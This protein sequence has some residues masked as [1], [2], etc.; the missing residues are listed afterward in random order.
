M[1]Y[2]MS[3]I[4]D[5]GIPNADM[6]LIWTTGAWMLGLAL[7]S[8]ACAVLTTR[9]NADVSSNFTADLRRAIFRKTTTLSFEEFSKVGTSSLLT[10]S[11]HDV[12]MLGD[13]ASMVV[14]AVMTVPV[15]FFGGCVFAFLSD[16]VLA[17]VFLLSAPL[18]LLLTWLVA[19]KVGV[20]WENSDKYI[21]EQNR[22]MRE[23]LSGLRVIRAFDKEA[24]EHGRIETATNRMAEN[25]IKANVRANLLTPVC[26]LLLNL[27]T[28][29]MLCI[30]AIRIQNPTLVA[31]GL[32][33]GRII[34]TV[35]YVALILNGLL[36]LS[37]TFI[38]MPHLKVCINRVAEVL[39]LKGIAEQPA[40]ETVTEGS[41]TFDHVSF[42]YPDSELETLT[43]IDMQI[44]AG[45]SVAVI[46]GTGSG[47]STLLKL[48]LCFYAPTQG[49]ISL[50]GKPY[51]ALGRTTVRNNLSVALQ[52]SMV[53][54][55]TIRDNVRMGDKDA[56]EARIQEAVRLSQ[57]E[58]YVESHPEGL[59]Y[60]LSQAG[61]NLSG[62]QK[63][64][65]N[66][67]RTILKPAQVY[68]FDDSFSA[69]DYLTESKLRRGLNQHLKGKTQ[70][71]ITQRAATAMRCD[72]IYVLEQGRIVGSG[73]HD[74]LM[75]SCKVYREIVNSQLG[76]N[77]EAHESNR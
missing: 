10:R 32:T 72:R 1:P 33:A 73:A 69:L 21:D 67:A 4:V 20:L 11:T 63:Q 3:R 25:I 61:A 57:M 41:I 35:Q 65:I 34:A 39:N 14:Y 2:L 64:R 71:I 50:S 43:D 60:K 26:M 75:E 7:L 74:A 47:K 8:T 46:G 37:W 45:E 42:A 5:E 40:M 56:S 52:K 70:L 68:I 24:F 55:G 53:F 62:G 58:S 36:V 22:L 18:V 38:L 29:V 27:A 31:N 44:A 17:L 51:A 76:G 12:M 49:S 9:V 15:L 59:D 6:T 48:L 54:A 19:R 13:S 66:I 23:R 30:G 77:R 16:W 28:I